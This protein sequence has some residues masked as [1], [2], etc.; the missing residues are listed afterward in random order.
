MLLDGNGHSVS[1]STLKRR[2]KRLGLKRKNNVYNELQIRALIVEEV[3]GAG[4]LSGYR[5]IWHSLRLRHGVHVSR[6]RVAQ[7]LTETDPDGA[8]SRKLKK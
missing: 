6:H 2:L 1:L 3:E 7:L 5:G 4:R 8:Q